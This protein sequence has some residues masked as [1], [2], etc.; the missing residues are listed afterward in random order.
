MAFG[1]PAGR[2]GRSRN[3]TRSP[4]AALGDGRQLGR[5]ARALGAAHAEHLEARIPRKGS[6]PIVEAITAC[7]RPTMTSWIASLV[8]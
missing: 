5:E 3:R 1:M 8:P 6:A 2:A 7:A 4:E